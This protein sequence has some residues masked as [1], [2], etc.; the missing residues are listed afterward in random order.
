MED[1]LAGKGASAE[2]TGCFQ[3]LSLGRGRRCRGLSHSWSAI[4]GN[5]RGL[6]GH[7]MS[8]PGKALF[9]VFFIT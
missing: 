8:A 6:K 9:M 7:A 5:D 1:C 4:A 3:V 2:E